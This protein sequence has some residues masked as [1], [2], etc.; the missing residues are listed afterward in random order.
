MRPNAGLLGMIHRA[1]ESSVFSV[2]VAD[3]R[4]PD[5]PLTYVNPAF[6]RLTGYQAHEVVGRNCRFLQGPDTERRAVRA[7]SDAITT[8]SPCATM[9]LNYRKDGSKFWNR[10]QLSPVQNDT[11]ELI[12]YLGVQID[13]T[14]DMAIAS[15]ERERQKMEALGQ[16]AG[17]VAHEIN[18]ALQPILLMS[19]VLDEVCQSLPEEHR[20]TAATCLDSIREHALFARSVVSQ[21]LSFSRRGDDDLETVEAVDLVTGATRFAGELLPS[22]MGVLIET[23][24]TSQ[25]G[26]MPKIRVNRNAFSQIFTNLFTNAAHAMEGKGTIT[27]TV[28][29][30]DLDDTESGNLALKAGRY[31]RVDVIDTGTGIPPETLQHIFDPFFTTKEIGEG[32]GLGLS[33]VYGIVKGWSGTVIAES[34]AGGD[35]KGQTVSNMTRPDGSGLAVKNKQEKSGKTGSTFRIYVPEASLGDQ[36]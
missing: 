30:I 25:A 35:G 31:V 28:T 24:Q 19:E 4:A 9:I 21:V 27:V 18:N 3:A 11:G 13:M 5:L 23:D 15:L 33:T 20:E 10:F 6:E 17:G 8:Q 34:R 26:A 22:T 14:R 1:V 2:T 16:L 29:A 36:T 7:I 32:T 12:A